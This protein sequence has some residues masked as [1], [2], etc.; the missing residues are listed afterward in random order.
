MFLN[1]S[2]IELTSVKGSDFGKELIEI[3]QFVPVR[4]H[5]FSDLP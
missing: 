4:H 2:G 1:V 3:S 5:D